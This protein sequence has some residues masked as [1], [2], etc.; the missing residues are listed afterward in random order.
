M[1]H[2]K[3]D[4]RDSIQKV[5]STLYKVQHINDYMT[6]IV[7]HPLL[8]G[9]SAGKNIYTALFLEVNSMTIFVFCGVG[10]IDETNRVA[11]NYE[12]EGQ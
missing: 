8:Y 10:F 12:D 3:Y 9:I 2:F 6:V 7:F 4:M 11:A 5:C 1:K